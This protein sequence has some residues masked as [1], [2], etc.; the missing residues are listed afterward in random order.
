MNWI[1]T[2]PWSQQASVFG[3]FFAFFSFFV[4][5]NFGLTLVNEC[6]YC[7]N[8][9]EKSGPKISSKRKFGCPENFLDTNFTIRIRKKIFDASWSWS[10]RM[11]SL[12]WKGRLG[13]SHT[14]IWG[15]CRNFLKLF[16]CQQGIVETMS[17]SRKSTSKAFLNCLDKLIKILTIG[18][19]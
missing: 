12:W 15:T 2:Q 11:I 1:P 19:N 3:M 18:R 9:N 8:H 7:N 4:T 5:I 17:Q 6:C 14:T 10:A 13:P 16:V